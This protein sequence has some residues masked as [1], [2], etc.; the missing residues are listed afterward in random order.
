MRGFDLP[1]GS[2]AP[3]DLWSAWNINAL[4]LISL[5]AT[6]FIYLWGM[7]NVWR[8]AGTGHG[9]TALRGLCFAGTML[10]L[11]AALVSPLDAL[12]HVLFSA[13]MAQHLI[14][15]LVAA[16]LL[17]LSDFPL[18]LLWALPRR[19]GQPLG[20]YL[21]QSQMLS[22]I[23]HALCHPV[24]AWLLFTIALWV[25]HAPVLF[26][27][28]LQDATIHALEHLAFLLTAMLFWWVL[29]KPAGQN[30]VRYGMAIP[31][32]FTTALQSGILG[33]LITFTAQPWYSYYT[34]LVTR[35]GLTPLQDQQLAGL[36][37]WLPGGVVFTL[38]TI[39]YFAAWF[40]AIERRA[41]E[42]RNV[43]LQPRD[44]L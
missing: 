17:M 3:H 20:R 29:F 13:H 31:Y 24:S 28:A 8:R 11:V 44:P 42:Q 33:A 25:W 39:G 2:L 21:N 27:A 43:L 18:A 34:P 35:W 38:L 37:M 6:G 26:E 41:S 9:I 23:S 7:R 36:L 19:W 1:A 15:I 40:S 4:L 30:Y 32:L 16:P 5:E 14:L 12:S 10:A 22:R